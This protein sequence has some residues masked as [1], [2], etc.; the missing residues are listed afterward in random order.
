MLV[1]VKTFVFFLLVAAPT[2]H[3]QASVGGG[4][5]AAA[6]AVF[7]AVLPRARENPNTAL[8][9]FAETG[10]SEAERQ[11]LF[12]VLITLGEEK[13]ISRQQF[14]KIV[15]LGLV[16]ADDYIRR[17]VVHHLGDVYDGEKLQDR[18]RR[19]TL[20]RSYEARYA[21]V[22]HMRDFPSQ[23]SMKYLG[24]LLGDDSIEVRELA[25]GTLA[26]WHIA[27]RTKGIESIFL[28]ALES[29]KTCRAGCA[30]QAFVRISDALPRPDLL[31]A[32]LAVELVGSRPYSNPSSTCRIIKALAAIA[33]PSSTSVL[34]RATMHTNQFIAAEARE[35]LDKIADAEK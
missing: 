16:D 29:N 10:L 12:M 1:D 5:G 4:E 2:T 14:L 21:A 31:N 32:Y 22:E 8:Q 15:E 25:A 19:S 6:H 13:R 20:D 23:T 34:T 28:R 33:D 30:A 7:V 27:G 9:R 3:I 35:A 17:Y 18:Y 26:Q 24:A 11:G